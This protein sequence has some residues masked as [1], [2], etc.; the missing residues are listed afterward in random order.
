[1]RAFPLQTSILIVLLRAFFKTLVFPL[2]CERD[3]NRASHAKLLTGSQRNS[4]RDFETVPTQKP[5]QA[6]A[7]LTVLKAISRITLRTK[8]TPTRCTL[9]SVSSYLNH[10]YL[11]W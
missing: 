10:S 1:M 6:R 3:R 8:G 7:A 9:P 5:D 2:C 11:E 4:S